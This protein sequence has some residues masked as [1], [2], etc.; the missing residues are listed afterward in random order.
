MNYMLSR[1]VWGK[2]KIERQRQGRARGNF[3]AEQWCPVL[4]CTVIC[5]SFK[6][7]FGCLMQSHL[8]SWVVIYNHDFRWFRRRLLRHKSSIDITKRQDPHAVRHGAGV[9]LPH[10]LLPQ[11]R[12]E[13]TEHQQ[14][15]GENSNKNEDA[16]C[17]RFP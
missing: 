13:Q 9:P 17:G 7:I 15:G 6:F 2:D 4:Y 16:V 3:R 8:F 10:L 14:H 11:E 1:V 5:G 12:E